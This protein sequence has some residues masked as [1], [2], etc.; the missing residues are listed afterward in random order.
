MY[1]NVPSTREGNISTGHKIK[2]SDMG[3]GGALIFHMNE[4][5]HINSVN[6]VSFYFMWRF[7]AAPTY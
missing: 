3:R 1:L 6:S 4:Y 5:L 7:G 2:Y